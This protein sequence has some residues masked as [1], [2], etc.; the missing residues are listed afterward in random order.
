[1]QSDAANPSAATE[2]TGEP[3]TFQAAMQSPMKDSDAKLDPLESF[4]LM[5]ALWL[6]EM[7]AQ[8]TS[9]HSA[10]TICNATEHARISQAVARDCVDTNER[11]LALTLFH[12]LTY[13]LQDHAS[14]CSDV[15]EQTIIDCIDV[16]EE[17]LS[18][19]EALGYTTPQLL[20][21]KRIWDVVTRNKEG[22]DKEHFF[23]TGAEKLLVA[24]NHAG[25]LQSMLDRKV[26]KLQSPNTE[27]SLN[28]CS[29]RS[30][31]KNRE[32]IPSTSLK[33]T[34]RSPLSSAAGST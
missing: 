12:F 13:I 30:F 10:A 24:E 28:I 32:R 1:M 2:H 11:D 18:K 21:H 17:T 34:R 19:D 3:R 7:D 27:H 8:T 29:I 33:R 16:V 23:P 14:M 31:G 9:L 20:E 26:K 4:Q 6:S 5:D 15:E 25:L 22:H